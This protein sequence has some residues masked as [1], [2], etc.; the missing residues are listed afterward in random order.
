VVA[1]GLWYFTR[2]AP[3]PSPSP[4]PTPS[5]T[6]AP[7]PTPTPSPTPPPDNKVPVVAAIGYS[8]S[9][10]V[11]ESVLFSAEGSIDPDGE[12]EEYV[13]YFGDGT[14]G[15]GQTARHSYD[16]PGYYVV[17]VEAEDD[18]GAKANT[19]TTPVFLKV[20]REELLEVSLESPPV[21]IIGVS[22]SVNEVGEEVT[23]DGASSYHYRDRNGDIQSYT[24]AVNAWSWDLGEGTTVEGETTSFTY[25]N[26]GSYFVILTVKDALNARGL[27][28]YRE[29]SRCLGYGHGCSFEP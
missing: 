14:T 4:S 24:P 19:I 2:P 7:S 28:G 26:A 16:L 6:P 8:T 23:L 5:P 11:G 25:D 27:P 29:E 18:D 1:A 10:E 13:W 20:E 22:A 9:A 3:T 15:V 12:I 21:A 17:Y